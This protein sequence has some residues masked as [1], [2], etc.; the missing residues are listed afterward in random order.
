MECSYTSFIFHWCIIV[1]HIFLLILLGQECKA[2]TAGALGPFLRAIFVESNLR[3]M[4]YSLPPVWRAGLLIYCLKSGSPKLNVP[5][6]QH[7]T[8]PLPVACVISTFSFYVT[9]LRLSGQMELIQ[10]WCH[11]LCCEYYNPSS[12]TQKSM[13]SASIHETAIGY[14][15]SL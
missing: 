8:C 9:P 1:V 12:L 2:L 11:F 13:Y 4:K 14:V 6:L 5:Q 7:K 10:T 15:I 3:G